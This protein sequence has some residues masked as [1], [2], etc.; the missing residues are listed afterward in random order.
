MIKISHKYRIYGRTKGRKKNKFIDHNFFN[1]YLINLKKDINKNKKTILDIGS[2]SGENS[3]F[4][5]K[6]NPNA[7]IIACDIF[8]DGNINL[9]N[10]L[11][12]SKINNIKLFTGNVVKLFDQLK[13]DYCFNE[14]WILFPDPWPKNRHHKRRLIK[15]SFFKKIHPLLKSQSKIFISTD[16]VSYLKSILISIYNIKSLFRW[17]NDRPQNWIYENKNLPQTK[18]FKKGKDAY[19]PSIYI[20]LEKI[21]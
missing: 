3:L 12:K 11:L 1:D 20:E 10:N 19:R 7:L 4:L 16:S 21:S 18:F 8:Q 14:V 17:Q 2:G 15:T 6:N 5:A 13:L 9:Y